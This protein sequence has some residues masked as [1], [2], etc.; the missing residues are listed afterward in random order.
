[1]LN[2]ILAIAA[3]FCES[4]KK[5][6]R[7]ELKYVRF[8]P[9]GK[10]IEA[11]ATD[12]YRACYITDRLPYALSE[13]PCVPGEGKPLQLDKEMLISGETVLDVA[14]GLK[15]NKALPILEEAR[16]YSQEGTDEVYKLISTDLEHV[17]SKTFRPLKSE[18]PNLDMVVKEIPPA[19]IKI[20]VNAQYLMEAAKAAHD[21][22][23]DGSYHGFDTVTL[24]IVDSKTPIRLV[25]TSH[26]Y[27]CV[28][29]IMPI[30]Q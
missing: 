20:E 8:T 9:K 23:K 1:M 22:N 17:N 3:R 7:E 12:S 6:G 11:C 15:S 5:P 19:V 4:T 18:F 25:T 27:D 21:L 29:V 2:K 28:Q 30:R 24:E 14:K 16:L 26:R 10:Y 13:A